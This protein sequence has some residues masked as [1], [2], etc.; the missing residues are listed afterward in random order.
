MKEN[1][2]IMGKTAVGRKE[3][4]EV[5]IQSK[6]KWSEQSGFDSEYCKIGVDK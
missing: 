3:L 4:S 1:F 6:N 2:L 5:T